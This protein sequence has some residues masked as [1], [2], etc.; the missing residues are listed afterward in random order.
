QPSGSDF[1]HSQRD[2]AVETI[3]KT[4]IAYPHSTWV[5]KL[6]PADMPSPYLRIIKAQGATNIKVLQ[7]TD[8]IPVLAQ[9]HLVVTLFSTTGIEA[10]LLGKPLIQVNLSGQ[11]DRVSYADYG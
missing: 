1:S 3:V 9:A 5:F 10:M 11:P 2:Q 8:V 7:D 4:A 6:H